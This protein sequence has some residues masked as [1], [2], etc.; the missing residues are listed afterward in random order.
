MIG[1]Y[2]YR[3]ATEAIADSH[4]LALNALQELFSMRGVLFDADVNIGDRYRQHLLS[5]LDNT[6]NF[7]FQKHISS[8]KSI[9][10]AVTSLQKHVLA[11]YP[12]E[13]IDD[14]LGSNYL[15][16]PY[17]FAV[18]SLDAG[19]PITHIG[20]GSARWQDINDNWQ[21]VVLEWQNIGGTNVGPH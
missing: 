11:T 21:S 12:Y 17:S 7:I 10:R 20:D 18:F 13:T 3:V 6:Y 4:D 14:F 8:T 16:V 19:F 15:E 1:T 5:S 9:L 2:D